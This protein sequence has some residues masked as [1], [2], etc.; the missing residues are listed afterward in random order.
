MF[1]N[2]ASK[3]ILRRCKKIF[4]REALTFRRQMIWVMRLSYLTIQDLKKIRKIKKVQE[5]MEQYQRRELII[6]T[7]RVSAWRWGDQHSSQNKTLQFLTE[8]LTID[9]KT[10]ILWKRIKTN[11][12]QLQVTIN[13]HKLIK[14]Y[15]FHH[16]LSTSFRPTKLMNQILCQQ[17]K[18][19][20]HSKKNTKSL[21][22]LVLS[23]R[24]HLKFSRQLHMA[25]TRNFRRASPKFYQ[26]TVTSTMSSVLVKMPQL[27]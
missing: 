13:L 15:R 21:Q 18:K 19:V 25:C 10:S 26:T 8:T 23:K 11:Y 14:I 1:N 12:W 9:L 20:I 16:Q 24:W 5:F 7:I 27:V 4:H 3:I 22:G 17:Y 6:F 2:I